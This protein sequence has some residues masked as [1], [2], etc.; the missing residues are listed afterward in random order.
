M[1]FRQIHDSASNAL[2]YLLADEEAGVAVVVDPLRSQATLILAMLAE[3]N[4]RLVHV[5][6]THVHQ[7]ARAECGEL[8][9]STGA[10]LI[11]GADSPAEIEGT[12]VEE[13]SEIRCGALVFR[14][15]DTPGHAP[16]SVCYLC[17]DRLLCGDTLLIENRD[18]VTADEDPGCLFDSVKHKLLILPDETLVFPGHDTRGRTISSIGEERRRN[19]AFT[20]PSREAFVAETRRKRRRQPHMQE[21]ALISHGLGKW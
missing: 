5:L 6:R 16:G 15:I 21:S 12:R 7:P 17:G 10:T 20:Q 18:N 8:C 2:T 11:L 14:V 3:R 1:Y 9:P 19:I 13:G 4:L